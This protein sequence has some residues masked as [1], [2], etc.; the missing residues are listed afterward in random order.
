V[1]RDNFIINILSRMIVSNCSASLIWQAWQSDRCCF[2]HTLQPLY[3]M[4]HIC[5]EG[6]K[7]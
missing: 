4:S 5:W 7:H 1:N 3:C 6:V 2:R